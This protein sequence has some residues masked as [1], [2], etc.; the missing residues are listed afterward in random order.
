MKMVEMKVNAS[1]LKGEGKVLEKL[2]DFLKEKTS[3]DVSTESKTLIVKGEGEAFSKKYIKIIIKKFLHK[4][5]LTASFRVIGDEE[6]ALKI[7]ERKVY[8]D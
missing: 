4:N 5:E 2:A 8:V 3:G 7:K 6:N 1:E